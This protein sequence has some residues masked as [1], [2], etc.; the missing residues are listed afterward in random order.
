VWGVEVYVGVMSHNADT[1]W[2][3]LKSVGLCEGVRRS[4]C[5]RIR[6]RSRQVLVLSNTL[7]IRTDRRTQ[8]L[9]LITAEELGKNSCYLA[10]V[11]PGVH[12]LEHAGLTNLLPVCVVCVSIGCVRRC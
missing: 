8:G 12:L 4:G 7:E 10:V 6:E 9:I 3:S 11:K 5:G 2:V 1:L